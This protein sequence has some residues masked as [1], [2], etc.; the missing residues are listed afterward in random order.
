MKQEFRE[1]EFRYGFSFPWM[2][3]P[4]EM[5]DAIDL[6]ENALETHN[7]MDDVYQI[8]LQSLMEVRWKTLGYR[9]ADELAKRYDLALPEYWH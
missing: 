8:E 9:I 7:L 4:V 6:L 3:L 2:M 5:Q 1:V